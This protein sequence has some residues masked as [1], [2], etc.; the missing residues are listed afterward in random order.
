MGKIWTHEGV[1]DTFALDTQVELMLNYIHNLE[2][3]VR[4]KF[5]P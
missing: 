3:D 1:P 5:D 4:V 2:P